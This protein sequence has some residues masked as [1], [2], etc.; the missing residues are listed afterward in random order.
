MATFEIFAH[1]DVV[2]RQGWQGDTEERPLTEVG[3]RQAER[4]AE[5]LLAAG[6][7]NGV[8]AST[9]TRCRQSVEPLAKR[10]GTEVKDAP[11]FQAPPNQAF[12]QGDG[13]NPLNP[14]YQAGSTYA[15]LRKIQAGL[16][17]GRFVICS[18]GG[19]I[20]SSL[21]AFLAGTRGLEV[22]AQLEVSLGGG[23]ADLRRGNVST[24]VLDGDE[25]ILRQRV[26]A[27]DFPQALPA[28]A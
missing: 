28:R 2:G 17:N 14:A 7:V 20:I 24:V 11:G 3:R 26:A 18:N 8:F 23:T 4:I 6:P 1:L 12:G 15:D 19:D 27:P 25:V 13:S 22:P 9:N 5:E 21:L 16:P 10:A